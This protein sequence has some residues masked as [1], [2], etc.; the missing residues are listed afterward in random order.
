MNQKIFLIHAISFFQGQGVSVNVIGYAKECEGTYPET[1]ISYTFGPIIQELKHNPVSNFFGLFP[2]YKSQELEAVYHNN[3]FGA[4]IT[5]LVD[6]QRFLGGGGLGS[7]Y[8]AEA[9]VDFGYVGIIV[10]NF[11]F[12]ILCHSCINGLDRVVLLP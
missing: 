12:G 11:V 10:V 3:N 4:T 5:Y 9:W 7:S 2:F 8:I 1:N 6:P